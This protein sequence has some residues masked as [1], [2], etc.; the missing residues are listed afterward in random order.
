[1]QSYCVSE[2]Q[3]LRPTE[4]NGNSEDSEEVLVNL[5]LDLIPSIFECQQTFQR[6]KSSKYYD[7]VWNS[8]LLRVSLCSKTYTT[9]FS[10]P[11]TTVYWK[12]TAQILS[13]SHF[14]VYEN[15]KASIHRNLIGRIERFSYLITKMASS[16]TIAQRTGWWFRKCAGLRVIE[17]SSSLQ[18]DG[19]WWASPEISSWKSFAFL[20]C[21]LQQL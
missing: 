19:L 3:I 10:G 1:M 17:I 9:E 14:L 15:S 16:L 8:T 7:D 4:F 21:H 20:W 2:W 12:V 6:L 5:N 11:E 13:Y 18:P